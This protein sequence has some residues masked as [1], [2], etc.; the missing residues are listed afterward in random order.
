MHIIK[1]FFN[2]FNFK[3]NRKQGLTIRKACQEP[4]RVKRL[5]SYIQGCEEDTERG[6]INAT[7]SGFAN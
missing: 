2:V 3:S 5:L 1:P 4:C 7:V 6:T